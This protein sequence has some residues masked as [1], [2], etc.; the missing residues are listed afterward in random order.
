M[1]LRKILNEIQLIEEGKRMHTNLSILKNPDWKKTIVW[2]KS[3]ITGMKL[4]N[5]INYIGDCKAHNCDINVGR[6]SSKNKIPHI[7]FIITFADM[8]KSVWPSK[9]FFLVENDIVIEHTEMD[10]IFNKPD[11]DVIYLG[12]PIPLEII[13]MKDKGL[14]W[15]YE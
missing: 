15:K 10:P 4:F 3:K 7:G 8:Y 6:K 2:C 11:V 9:H 5:E 13:K 1:K 12:K 14:A